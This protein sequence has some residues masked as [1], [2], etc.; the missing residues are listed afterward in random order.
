MEGGS[1]VD[2]DLMGE[3]SAYNEVDC[4]AMMEAVRYFRNWY[5]SRR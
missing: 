2:V 5:R 1:L 3:V 4:R